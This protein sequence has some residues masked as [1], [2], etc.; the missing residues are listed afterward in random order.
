MFG[1]YEVNRGEED[2]WDW[3]SPDVA[4]NLQEIVI[5]RDLQRQLRIKWSGVH[6]R[7]VCKAHEAS[8]ELRAI[9]ARRFRR[10]AR[11]PAPA[12]C[13]LLLHDSAAVRWW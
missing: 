8:R 13:A 11:G 6:A 4:G 12:L 5:P 2:V 1:E 7:F 10:I 3:R 9:R